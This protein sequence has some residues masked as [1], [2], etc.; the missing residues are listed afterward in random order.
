MQVVRSVLKGVPLQKQIIALV[1]M[2]RR[3]GS[4][5]PVQP[6]MNP[7][8]YDQP[9][10]RAVRSSPFSPVIIFRAR[11]AYMKPASRSLL[12]ESTTRSDGHE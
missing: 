5:A 12:I 4:V 3:G 11:R 7:Y 8:A 9:V 2:I 1:H 10:M 6:V